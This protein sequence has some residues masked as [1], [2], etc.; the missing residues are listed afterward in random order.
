[1]LAADFGSVYT[2][3]DGDYDCNKGVTYADEVRHLPVARERAQVIHAWL[4]DVIMERHFLENGDVAK[5]ESTRNGILQHLSSAML[6]YQNC[7][8]AAQN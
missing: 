7:R 4:V 6:A 2:P 3:L 8:C 1:M 5:F